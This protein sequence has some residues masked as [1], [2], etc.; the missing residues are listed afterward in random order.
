MAA[1]PGLDQLINA[2]DHFQGLEENAQT[3][4]IN[5]RRTFKPVVGPSFSQAPGTIDVFAMVYAIVRKLADLL[6]SGRFFG[7]QEDLG[8]ACIL[9]DFDEDAVAVART[10]IDDAPPSTQAAYRLHAALCAFLMAYL[11]PRAAADWRE[12]RASFAWPDTFSSGWTTAVRLFDLLCAIS[13]LTEHAPNHVRRVPTP[14]WSLLLQIL[15]DAGPP[16]LVTALHSSGAA[17]ITSR[18]DMKAFLT[19]QD[20]GSGPM[21]SINALR[22]GREFACWKC[23]IVG[24]MARNWP[25]AGLGGEPA[26]PAAINA[27]TQ[28]EA[29]LSLFQRQERVQEL[30]LEAQARMAQQDARVA[31]AGH[32]GNDATSLAQMTLQGP[33]QANHRAPLIVGGAQP[34][35]YIY[36]GLDRGQSVWAHADIVAASV[37]DG[38]E[39]GSKA[40][41]Q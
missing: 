9:S 37:G 39:A 28:D 8:V 3:V 30:M 15:E 26:S 12:L 40:G 27:L 17:N 36:I 24:H 21:G 7:A 11:P 29:L 18:A 14:P 31:A 33:P 35:E 32:T 41:G 5:E 10:A 16:W 38:G 6:S 23:G 4:W 2:H 20:L 19:V 1:V 25:S 34:D 22:A 13:V